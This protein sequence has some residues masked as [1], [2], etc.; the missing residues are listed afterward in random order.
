MIFYKI[1]FVGNG[2]LKKII[3]FKYRVI[4]RVFLL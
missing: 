2:N 1:I 4:D 3:F